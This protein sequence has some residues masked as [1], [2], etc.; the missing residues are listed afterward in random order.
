LRDEV[1]DFVAH[2]SDRTALPAARL[3]SGVGIAKGKFYAWKKRYGKANEH[4]ARIPR[5]HWLES[6][7][8]QAILDFHAKHPL[9]GYRRLAFMGLDADAFAVSPSSAYRVLRAAGRLD[10]SNQKPSKKGTGFTQP[11]GA[12]HHWHI[13]V[14]YLNIA[15]TFYYLCCVLDGYSRAI[16]HWE[17]REAMKEADIETILERAR[18]ACPGVSPRIISDN[19][20]QFIA[21]DFKTYIRLAGMTHV[22]TSPYYP[23]S[24]G[25]IEALHKTIKMTTIRP[26]APESLDEARRLMTRFVAHYNNVRLHSAIGYVAPAD[27]LAGRETQIWAARDQRLAAARSR[28]QQRRAEARCAA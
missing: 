13:D 2:W 7:E 24:N 9:E 8:T 10:R 17:A 20:P 4:N 18:E 3:V 27:K 14:T 11:T 21:R 12:H 23:Q 1:V 22:R 16:I 19:G 28:R 5:D 6:E 25:K 15:G 26:A